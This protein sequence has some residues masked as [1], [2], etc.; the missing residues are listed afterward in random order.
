MIYLIEATY[1]DKVN[2]KIIDLLKIGY[3]NNLKKRFA[4]Y[5]SNNPEVQLLD[6]RSG[7]EDLE[8][9]LHKYFSKYKYP[10]LEEWF[11]YDDEIVDNFQ[12]VNLP[13]SKEDEEMVNFINEVRD[14]GIKYL[15]RI[16]KDIKNMYNSK[17]YPFDLDI[18]SYKNRFN[19]VWDSVCQIEKSFKEG[20][21]SEMKKLI[22]L[23]F[24]EFNLSNI[25]KHKV[26]RTSAI[27]SIF[28]DNCENGLIVAR[29][30]S[31]LDYYTIS[32][33]IV[34]EDELANYVEIH[35]FNSIKDY[36]NTKYNYESKTNTNFYLTLKNIIK[37]LDDI[38]VGNRY[39]FLE[40][41]LMIKD[42]YSEELVNLLIDY[43]EHYRIGRQYILA[44]SG[45]Y[46]NSLYYNMYPEGLHYYLS[47]NLNEVIESD[48]CNSDFFELTKLADER[49]Y[50]EE[51][52]VEYLLSEYEEKTLQ[53][54]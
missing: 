41:V 44:E 34:V 14:S 53:I 48:E 9:Y 12:L 19:N 29:D 31:L 11:Y 39:S 17:N 37:E 46:D 38:H 3:T 7:G 25:I 16:V 43:I 33:N 40:Y 13:E 27:L 6:D 26:S 28:N 10:K 50:E 1:Y 24:T 32:D 36:F 54:L 45:S 20:N 35:A 30:N 8:K 5:V 2:K 52:R 15:N 4:Q 23:I 18:M 22:Q 42:K 47:L 49:N 51:E 21:M